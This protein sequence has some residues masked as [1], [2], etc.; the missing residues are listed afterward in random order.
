MGWRI[1]M[2][3]FNHCGAALH[4][5]LHGHAGPPVLLIQGVGVIGH[6]WKPQVDG[7]ASTHR[8]LTFDNRG[9]GLSSL[10]R[11]APFSIEQMAEDARALLDAAGWDSAHVVGHSMGGVIAQRLA[12]AA[13]SR[14][15]SLSLLC[16]V[17]HGADAVRMTPRMLW[18]ALRSNLGPKPSRRRAFLGLIYPAPFLATADCAALAATL[19]PLFGHDLAGQSPVA[20][21]QAMALRKHDCSPE[22]SQLAG[23]PTL[24]LSAAHDPIAPPRFG[25]A[26]AALIP[27]ARFLEIPDASHAVPIQHA[28]EVNRL[29]AA[30]IAAAAV[31][32]TTARAS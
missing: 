26:L 15:Q 22:L 31:S 32:P 4:Y 28:V 30:H 18:T 16:T 29:L 24:V 19:A 14:V 8:M 5:E 10:R 7:L 25:R 20:M 13:P 6:G 1:P 11:G 21:K 23:V 27:G 9:I 12:L 2:P 17:A 3:T